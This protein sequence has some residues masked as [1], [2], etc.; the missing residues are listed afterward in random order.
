VNIRSLLASLALLAA[1]AYAPA[2]LAQSASD[3]FDVTITITSTCS[4]DAATA[5]N[6]DFLSVAS[7]ATNVQATGT[8]SVTCTNGTPYSVALGE[9]SNNA[10]GGAAGR[11]MEAGGVL[12]PYQLYSDASR[13][14]VWDDD[15]GV[16]AGTGS[17]SAQPLTVY[18]LVPS[19]N[20]P[21]GNYSDTVTATVTY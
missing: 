5:G 13:T 8:L 20:F 12:V 7:T 1:T 9:G 10:G 16:V 4:I 11:R 17:G 18:G 19:A 2:T 21:A 15:A 14:V 3:D 6:I